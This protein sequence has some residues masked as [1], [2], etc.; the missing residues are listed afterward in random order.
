VRVC[1]CS[2]NYIGACTNSLRGT[3]SLTIAICCWWYVDPIRAADITWNGNGTGIG[4]INS[5]SWQNVD[6]WDRFGSPFSLHRVPDDGDTVT[7]NRRRPVR[8]NGNTAPINGLNVEGPV[9]FDT[10][11]YLLEVDNNGAAKTHVAS[12][13]FGEL[14]FNISPRIGGRLAFRTSELEI[15]GPDM[16]PSTGVNFAVWG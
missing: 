16:D 5:D 14:A 13:N 6:N 12:D 8:L 2:S 4:G 9:D 7:L 3:L 11:G 10:N 1:S 15:Y